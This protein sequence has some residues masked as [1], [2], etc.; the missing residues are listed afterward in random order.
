MLVGWSVDVSGGRVDASHRTSL[1][2]TLGAGSRSATIESRATRWALIVFVVAAAITALLLMGTR[3]PLAGRGSLGNIAAWLVAAGAG[4][5]FCGAY[6]IEAWRGRDAWRAELPRAKRLIDALILSVAMAML[7]YLAITAI[8]NLFQ[9][10]FRGLTIDWLGGGALAG[11]AAA[12]MTYVAALSGS[13]TSGESIALIA[14]LQLFMG[15]MASMVSSPDASWWQ[16]HFSQLGNE[17]P[18]HPTR[19]HRRRKR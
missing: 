11:A 16:L 12:A 18:R 13:R 14:T 9:L 19:P 15:T 2:R 5:A 3:V 4:L 1:R 7:A 17:R 6:A 8:A 10:G